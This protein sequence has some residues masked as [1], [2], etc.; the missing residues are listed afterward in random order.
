MTASARPLEALSGPRKCAV[1]CMALGPKQAATILQQLSPEDLESVTREIASMPSVPGDLVRQVLQEF[2]NASIAPEPV[3]RGG[4]GFAREALEQAFGPPRAGALLDRL[5]E[6]PPESGL[7][8]LERTSPQV[9]A[10]MLRGEHPQTIA[11]VLAYLTPEQALA[12]VQA[13]EPPLGGEVL[14]RMARL[15]RVSTDVLSLV[16]GVLGRAT[17]VSLSS[18]MSASGGGGPAAV[19]RLLNLAGAAREKDLLEALGKHGPEMVEKIRAL[20]FVFEDLLMIDSKGMQRVLREIETKDLALALKA[21]S[22]ELRK[23]IASAMSE[24][25]TDALN[26][27]I[28]ILGPVRVKDVEAAHARIIEMVRGL[29]ESGEI[30]IRSRGGDDGIIG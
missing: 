21:A 19:A 25:A 23:H 20:M 6:P 24:R 26:E 27:E 29:E 2:Q 16:E 13:L 28:E 22:P 12:A 18:E 5:K 30:M 14:Y 3:A 10:G 1:L 7:K 9:L 4:P 15:D 17:D 8:R 11:L